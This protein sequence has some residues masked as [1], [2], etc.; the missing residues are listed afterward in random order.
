M[1]RILVFAAIAEAAT[2]LV[3]LFAPSLFAH[4]LFGQQLTGVAIPLAQVAGIALIALGVACSPASPLVGMLVYNAVVTLYF[5][6]LGSTTGFTGVLLWPAVVFHV[7]L[8]VLL[9]VTW[10]RARKPIT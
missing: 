1:K 7:T 6:F 5:A 3:L 9:A 10:K 2:G 8:T 4:L